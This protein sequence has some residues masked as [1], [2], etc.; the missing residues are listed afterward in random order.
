M[1]RKRYMKG[2]VRPRKHGRLKVWVAQ[3]WENGAR[4]SK[5]LGKCSE[6]SKGHAETMMASILEPLNESAGKR[7]VPVF[8]FK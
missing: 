7:Q 8:T 3:W 1:R 6:M 5:V 4:K 2:S